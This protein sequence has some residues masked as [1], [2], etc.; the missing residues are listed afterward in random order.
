M[1]LPVLGGDASGTQQSMTVTGIQ[2]RGVSA[3]GPADQN[4]LRWNA[5]TGQWE[6]GFVPAT[7]TALPPGTCAAGSLY[8]LNDTTNNIQQLYVCSNTNKWTMASIGS[9]LA[10][11]RPANCVAGQTWLSTDTG[12]MTYCSATGNPGTW[13]ATFAGAT[14]GTNGQG[15]TSN[16]SGGFGTA[17]TLPAGAIVG[18]TDTQTLTGKTLDGVTPATMSY[19]D[20]T[21]SIQAQLGTKAASNAS[22]TVNGVAC[23]L[24]GSC[25]V[26]D[27]TKVPASTT[28]NGHA[29]SS[30]V[31]VTPTD[32]SLVIGTNTEAWSAALDSWAAK[33]V[34]AGTPVGTTDTQTLTGKTLDGV[35]PTTMGYLDATSSIQ[36]QL[37]AK[38]PLASPT[39]T[40]TVGGIS[41]TM[42]GLGN[43]TNTAQ[44]PALGN[45]GTNGYVLS[46][47]TAGVR[48]WV[49]QTGGGGSSAGTPLQMGN[50]S[51][52][53]S[54]SH[55]SDNG[56]TV[57]AT[58]PFTSSGPI[59]AG[60]GSG[61]QGA[62]DLGQGSG[63]QT[64]QPA[65]SIR[66]AAPT[67]VTSYVLLRPGAAASGIP[68]WSNSSG[69][70]TESIAA[71]SLTADISGNL[72]IANLNSG[73]GASSSTCWHGDGT[74]GT[75]GSGGSSAGAN[76]AVETSNGSG[77]FSDGGCTMASGVL[78]CGSSFLAVG[79][80][81][82]TGAVSADTL[83]FDSTA[84][85]P[86]FTANGDSAIDANM[87]VPKA[88]RTAHQFLTN[89]PST[90][91]QASA[92]IVDT[93]LP[94]MFEPSP[95]TSLDFT[96]HTAG[97]GICTGTC[98]VTIPAPA[99]NNQ[100]CVRNDTGVTTAITLSA[101]GGSGAYE[102]TDESAYGTAGSGTMASGTGV[103]NK[104][105]IVGRDSTHYQVYSY[106]G[107][108]TV[109]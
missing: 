102:K 2:G 58:E 11:N 74:W 36:T 98:T 106:L 95:G 82:A 99:A 13:S 65:N 26:A 88:A 78:T 37:N 62:V 91:L 66:D 39:F 47:T 87:I 72:P 35:T 31:T 54:S 29:L 40:G 59:S 68:H 93:D 4:V 53:F 83:R 71:V 49:A 105:C 30:N 41:A 56:T 63:F 85:I 44:E 18:T 22:T 15:L 70:V 84:H 1:G 64:V 57:S 108:W 107:T 103:V 61:Y 27:A 10:A 80:E 109:N 24:S 79:A 6:P 25:T 21:S 28:V 89:V 48:S 16:G 8:L 33:T 67:S 19:L 97:Y 3:A 77:A 46:S 20:A 14:N 12:A 45:P 101:L 81:T 96:G 23:A 7:G 90:G 17:V 42:V 75:C 50:G 55:I 51:G 43:V 34:P 69:T 32:L 52:G 5:T 76:H 73:A 60:V 9:G 104:V 86:T 92:A 38:A 100:F 94:P